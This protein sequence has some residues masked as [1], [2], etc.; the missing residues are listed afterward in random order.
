MLAILWLA[1]VVCML[2]LIVPPM[3]A[4]IVYA[5][6]FVGAVL[7]APFAVF[8]TREGRATMKREVARGVLGKLG[9]K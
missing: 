8:G 7:A 5:I 4:A 2:I 9:G 3:F 1:F 6:V